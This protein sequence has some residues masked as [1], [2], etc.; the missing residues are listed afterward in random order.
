MTKEQLSRVT[1]GLALIAL[2]L[3]FLGD[4]L[5]VIPGI[6]LGRLWPVFIII[7]AL[8]RLIARAEGRPYDSL[9]WLLIGGILLMHTYRI[10]S[11]RDSWPLFI[12]VGGLMMFVAGLFS[13]SGRKES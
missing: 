6:S 8:V 7:A 3:I 5:D 11:I 1:W 13:H 4:R 12:V 9:G 10:M 2:G